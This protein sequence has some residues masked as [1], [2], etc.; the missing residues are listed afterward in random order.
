[1]ARFRQERAA[2][3]ARVMA[4]LGAKGQPEH[5]GRTPGPSEEANGVS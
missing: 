5:H 1:M 4:E 2:S 3:K